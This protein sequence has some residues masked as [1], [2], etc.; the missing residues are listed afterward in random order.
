MSTDRRIPGTHWAIIVG[1]CVF[2]ILQAFLI[3]PGARAHDFLNMYTGASLAAEGR[4]AELHNVD[5]QLQSEQQFYPDHIVLVPFVRPVF[6]AWMLSPLRL[7]SFSS[8][9]IVWVAVHS[10]LLIG[11]WIWAWWRFGANAL[12]FAALFLPGPVGIATGQ[13]CTLMLALLALAYEFSARE[14]YFASGAAL[15]L[16]LIKFHLVL[17]WP[18]AL[19]LQKRWKMLGGYVAA[20]ALE[21][22][23]TLWLGGINGAREYISLLQNKS[24]ERLS[25]APELMLSFQ[26]FTENAGVSSTLAT[27]LLLGSVIA[28][29]VFSVR[30]APLWRMFALTALA[31]LFITPH[32]YVY[33]AALVLVPILLTIQNASRPSTKIAATLFSTPVPYLLAWAGKPYA[34]AS[35]ASLLLVFLL[36]A[37]ESLRSPA[38]ASLP[39]LASEV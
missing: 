28:V 26:G 18:V 10:A 21:G 5:V 34:I 30:N 12:V 9:F 17:L 39:V 20:A 33:D 24:L 22:A 3:L 25:P 1:M 8:A 38:P 35:S 15:A 36:I 14:K 37:S 23:V 13:D 11:T 7:F 27:A 29:F 31:S 4:Y 2:W 16:M 32:V 6:Y 19:V